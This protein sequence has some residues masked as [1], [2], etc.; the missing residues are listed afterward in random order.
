MSTILWHDIIFGPILSRRIGHSLGVN[1][2]PK[3]GKICSFDCI[4]CECGW[5]KDGTSNHTI[6][7]KEMIFKA[8][9][10]RFAELSHNGTPVDSITF[11]G[12]GEP[13]IHPDFPAIID[14]TL[15]MRAKYFPKAKVSVL[16]NASQI[17]RKE[18]REALMK[19]DNP[20]LKIDSA[21]PEYLRLLNNP[22]GDYTLE[23]V[24]DNLRLFKGN[25]ILQTMFLKGTFNGRSID[26][27]DP[28]LTEPW[29]KLVLSLRPREVMMYTIDRETPAKGL[30]KVT[31]DEMSTIAAPLIKEGIIV[32]IK[33]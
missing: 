13:T 28:K 29:I 16:S 22:M 7:S 24:I 3:D 27:T 18:I 31:V 1:I 8:M 23:R 5:N 15:Q 25:F 4:Y 9:D 19:V 33:G 10:Q 21:V 20:I 14:Y 30:E 2:M 17:H 32:Q 6:P 12:N 11:S 26:S